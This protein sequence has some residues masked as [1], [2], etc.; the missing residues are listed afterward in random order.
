MLKKS[1]MTGQNKSRKLPIPV[2]IYLYTLPKFMFA[3]AL[4]T[5][6]KNIRQI[7]LLVSRL[8]Q[9]IFYCGG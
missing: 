5:A 4:R 3:S 6:T 9:M 1:N 2:A 8:F 7:L